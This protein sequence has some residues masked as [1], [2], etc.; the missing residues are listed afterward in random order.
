MPLADYFHRSAV[1]AAQVLSGYDEE[2]IAERLADTVVGVSIAPEVAETAEGSAA[3]DL[4]V[5]MLARMYP[6]LVIAGPKS[7]ALLALA[8]SINPGIE[9]DSAEPT[10]AI[11]IGDS[12]RLAKRTIYIGSAGWDAYVST[13]SPRPT[14]DTEIPFGA[15]TAACFGA[16]N[17][18]RE[19]FLGPGLS[20]RDA[21][22]STLE[23]ACHPT[24]AAPLLE[25]IEGDAVVVGLG[26]VGNAAVWTLGRVPL[27]GVLH[28][29]DGE[30][31]E[32]GNL[33]RYVLAARDD[34]GAQKT[35]VTRR[36]LEPD[37]SVGH[38]VSWADFVDGNGHRWD[39]VLV[40]VD[41]ARARHEVQASLPGWI[42]NAWTQPGDLGVSSHP[43][44][45]DGAC[46]SCLYLPQGMAPN[47]DEQ[48][49]LA[50]GLPHREFGLLLRNLLVTGEPPPPDLLER[51][52][53]ALGIPIE[54]LLPFAAR[55]IREL[56]VEGICGGAAVSLDR[57]GRPA[58]S[59]HVPLVH[60][61]ALAG[62][63]LAARLAA[64]QL[65]AAA[66]ST[67]VT[68]L[69]VQRILP[70]FPTQ[71]AKKDRRGICI[72]QDADYQA[73]WREKF[74]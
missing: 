5:R 50:L 46:L 29:V 55:P 71:P 9:L 6:K 56:Y 39:R 57:I 48:I 38:S 23:L 35:D 45:S 54:N 63:L 41:S 3:L 51:A 27:G 42:A 28:L 65:G 60:Q 59:V 1:A 52:A 22:F 21:V 16:A 18:F 30:S 19:V 49:A 17:I 33:Q 31:L 26:A 69:D 11:V 44:T 2:A 4:A 62:V 68:R 40:A 36:H 10:V 13:D 8:R 47:E 66:G 24:R 15:A 37:S 58:Q 32:L 43:W 25:Q 14:G 70:A 73:A 20:D 7:P 61:S 34:V 72:C 74:G 12:P 64:N 67:N 53:A